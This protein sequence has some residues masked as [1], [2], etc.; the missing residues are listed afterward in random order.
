MQPKPLSLGDHHC[1]CICLPRLS[2]CSRFAVAGHVLCIC[3][4]GLDGGGEASEI[5]TSPTTPV[6]GLEGLSPRLP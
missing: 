5:D 4:G 3:D 2:L 6:S 1:S